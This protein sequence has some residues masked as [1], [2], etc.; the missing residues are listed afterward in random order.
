M[1][2]TLQPA[3]IVR[4]LIDW[5]AALQ[6]A[7][8]GGTALLLA[9]VFLT[10]FF[11][12]GF[13]PEMMTR[14]FASALLGNDILAATPDNPLTW[15]AY[16]G[17]GLFHFAL[18][19]TFSMVVAFVVHRWSILWSAV[20]SGLLGLCLYAFNI[21]AVTTLLPHF[22]VLESGFFLGAHVCFGALVGTLYEAFE[23]EVFVDADGN[24]INLGSGT[25]T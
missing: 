7:V 6:A 3:P 20:A 8:I 2:P 9:T 25:T 16:L 22:F 13:S 14:Y 24:V 10:Q 11:K 5:G 1:P 4:Q 17:L 15:R 19:V 21:Y 23:F 12:P 18:A